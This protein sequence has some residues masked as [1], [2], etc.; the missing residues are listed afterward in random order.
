MLRYFLKAVALENPT[1]GLD[2]NTFAA[3][4]LRRGGVSAAWQLQVGRELLQGHGRWSSDAIDLY[5]QAG[6]ETK[7]TVTS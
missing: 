4:S 6:V 3:H 7:L 1:L 2:I 5:L